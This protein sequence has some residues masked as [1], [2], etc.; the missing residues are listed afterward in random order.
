MKKIFLCS[1]YA[2]VILVVGACNKGAGRT[3]G[4]TQNV[5]IDTAVSSAALLSLSLSSYGNKAVITK[6]AEN[7][8]TSRIAEATGPVFEFSSS[9]K[10]STAQQV[11]IAVT[12]GGGNRCGRHT[13]DSTIFTINL[14]SK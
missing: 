14:N 13:T 9:A 12:K 7:Y 4:V 5:T 10:I 1:L 11:V 2:A 6:Q 3:A 8:T